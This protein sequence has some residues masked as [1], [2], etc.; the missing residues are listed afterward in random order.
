MLRIAFVLLPLASLVTAS[1]QEPTAPAAG[2]LTATPAPAEAAEPATARPASGETAADITMR[3]ACEH[4]HSV[5]IVRGEIARVSLAD[6]RVIEIPR[7]AD[8]SP[9][10]YAGVALSFDV[11]SE[12]A[13][14]GQD[15]VGGSVC[16]EA[17]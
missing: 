4:G 9:P 11:G 14:L 3:Y 17:D 2:D 7:I 5:A 1:C 6:G 12:G 15:E 16:R 8:S 13:T 10:R